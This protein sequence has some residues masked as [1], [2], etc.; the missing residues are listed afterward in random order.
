MALKSKLFSGDPKLEAAAVS[1]PAHIVPGARGDHVSKIQ[2]ALIQLDGAVIDA[3]GAYGPATAA[4]VLAYKTK[5]SIINTT[6]QTTPDN[7]VGKMTMASL[8]A[9][10]AQREQPVPVPTGKKVEIKPLTFA[11]A[12]PPRSAALNFLISNSAL[13]LAAPKIIPSSGSNSNVVMELRRNSQG[14]ILVENGAPGEISI[15]DTSIAKIGQDAPLPPG[16]SELVV[17]DSQPFKVFSGKQLGRTTI[18]V[19]TAFG[20]S[21]SID[22]VVKTFQSLPK[23]TPGVNHNHAPS[24]QYA[25]VQANPNNAPSIEGKVLEIACPFTD[26]IGL[27]NLAKRTTFGDKPIA[28]KHLDFYLTDGK[29][30]DFNEDA[31]IKDWLTRD[32]GIRARLKKEIFPPGRKP[33]GQGHFEFDQGEYAVEDF[34]FAFGGIDRVDFEVDFSQDT[35]RVFFQDRYEWH[36]VYPFYSKFADDVLR[37]TNCL[38]AALVELKSKGAA[39]FWM[40]GEAEVSLS[41]IIA[42]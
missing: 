6:Y 39:D 33:V 32:S 21:A 3:D 16:Q 36:P 24:G 35:V 25:K 28:L 40:K 22:V 9:E 15:A 8:D 10:L 14:R 1:D 13:A 23:F 12:R 29:G 41:S 27:V 11:V 34:R 17:T 38:H 42:P 19:K 4:A 26:E 2:L 5:R 30:A 7:I 31:N 18:T 20:T 37:P